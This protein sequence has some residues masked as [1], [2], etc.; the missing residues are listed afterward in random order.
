VNFSQTH[1]IL[2]FSDSYGD[3]EMNMARAVQDRYG[4]SVS[5]KNLTEE[6]MTWALREILENPW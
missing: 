1:K 5:Y 3:Q 6:S 4:L 2:F